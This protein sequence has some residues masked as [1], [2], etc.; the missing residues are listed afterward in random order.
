MTFSNSAVNYTLSGSGGIAGAT[1]ITMNGTGGDN[2]YVA[3]DS[4]NIHMSAGDAMTVGGSSGG[5][6]RVVALRW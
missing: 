4:G 2:A 5:A 6:S 3:T 1:G